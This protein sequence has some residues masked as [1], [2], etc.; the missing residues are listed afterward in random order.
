MSNWVDIHLD[1][2]ATTPSEINQI[3]CALQEPCEEL[4]TWRA[5]RTGENPNEIA[6]SV[7]EI[8]SF[9]PIKTLGCI[10][11]SVNRARRF[12]SEWKDKFWGLVWSHVFFVSR[13]FPQAVFLVQY[14]DDSMSYGGKVV[15][16]ANKEI[17]SS[18]DGDHRAQGIEWVLPNIFAPF[19][20]EYEL[21]LGCGSLWHEWIESMRQQL[22]LLAERYQDPFAGN[23]GKG[24]SGSDGGMEK[25]E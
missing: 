10:H 5:Q 1:V 8:V 18:Y 14:R 22:A 9:K 4:V 11:P 12:E 7:K 23:P 20:T 19:R 24:K 13:D 25:A 16:H 3:E 15:I 6:A 17:C 21:G 2:L